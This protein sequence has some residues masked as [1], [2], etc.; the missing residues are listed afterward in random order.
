M[1]LCKFMELNISEILW[2]NSTPICIHTPC[3]PHKTRTD[4]NQLTVFA[5]SKLYCHHSSDSIFSAH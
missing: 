4:S 5:H 2:P 1:V 3:E